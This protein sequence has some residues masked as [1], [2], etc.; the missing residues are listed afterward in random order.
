[1]SCS[2]CKFFIFAQ[3]IAFAFELYVV[4]CIA[5]IMRLKAKY[6]GAPNFDWNDQPVK[7]ECLQVVFT[8]R[9]LRQLVD[10]WPQSPDDFAHRTNQLLA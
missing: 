10:T 8:I 2:F 6:N 7:S 5:E 3:K 1:M 9:K 4:R